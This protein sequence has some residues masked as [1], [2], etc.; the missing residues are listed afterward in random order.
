MNEKM[1]KLLERR[2]QLIKEQ[3]GIVNKAKAENRDLTDDERKSFDGKDTELDKIDKDVEQEKRQMKLEERKRS[4]EAIDPVT[5]SRSGIIVGDDREAMKPFK[6]IGEQLRAIRNASTPGGIVDKRLMQINQEYRAYTGPSGMNEGIDSEG[7]FALQDDFAGMLFDTAVKT[8]PILSRVDKYN[9]GGPSNTAKWVE[10]DETS[11]A[12]TVF[13]GVQVY[14]AAEADTVTASKPK[15]KERKL[16]L[17]KLFGL[18]YATDEMMEDTTFLTGLYNRAFSVAIERKLE[19][20]IFDGTGAGVPM[21]I[22]NSPVLV[23]VAKEAGQ[24]ADTL[25]Y[26]NF[27]KMYVRRWTYGAGVQN[28]AWFVHP[29]CEQ[30]MMLMDFPVGTGG[31]PV[32]LPPGGASAAPYSTLFGLP[33]IPTDHCEALGDKGDVYLNDMSEYI[34]INKGGMKSEMSIHVRFLYG[35]Q[36]FR[37]TYRANGMPKR[38]TALTIKNSSSTRSPFVTL[39]AR[40]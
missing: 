5:E 12:T 10:I 8:G 23:S 21:G 25:I 20:D 19:G 26:K 39:D 9:V 32:F 13:G 35:E 37:F 33:V 29:D 3:N 30:Q 28:L 27:L 14:W 2:E 16:A 38:N 17:E 11:I 1:K 36:T 24:A 40:A 7:A 31:V 34:L 22:L 18:A 6:N 4:L 15:L